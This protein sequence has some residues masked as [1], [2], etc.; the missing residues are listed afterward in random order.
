MIRL[1]ATA[2][3]LV[4]LSFAAPVSH[5]A[6]AAKTDLPDGPGKAIL[7]TACTTCHELAEVTK[8]RGFYTK[9]EWRDIVVTMVKYGAVVKEDEVPVLVEYLFKNF[10]KKDP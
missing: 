6:Q 8:F 4:A 2:L 9:D 7:L 10:G 3:S 1:Q 5:A